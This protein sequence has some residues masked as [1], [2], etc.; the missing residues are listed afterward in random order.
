LNTIYMYHLRS[1]GILVNRVEYR[2]IQN[3]TF[4]ARCCKFTNG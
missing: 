3:T 4:N 2:H 1:Q